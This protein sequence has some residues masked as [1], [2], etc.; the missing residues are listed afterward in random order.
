MPWYNVSMRI[1]MFYLGALQSSCSV[2]YSYYIYLIDS[3]AECGMD[4]PSGGTVMHHA[5]GKHNTAPPPKTVSL[6]FLIEKHIKNNES[7]FVLV[8]S[9]FFLKYFDRI[10]SSLCHRSHQ[11]NKGCGRLTYKRKKGSD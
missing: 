1:G 4:Q 11:K 5:G 6:L 9:I 3:R 7:L 2:S 8:T 10:S